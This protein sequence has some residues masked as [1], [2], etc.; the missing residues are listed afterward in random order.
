MNKKFLINNLTNSW[1][2]ENDPSLT[3]RCALI[4]SD[5]WIRL[6]KNTT[7]VAQCRLYFMHNEKRQCIIGAFIV[8]KKFRQKGYGSI[9]LKEVLKDVPH[10]MLWVKPDNCIA[11]HLYEKHGF[12]AMCEDHLGLIMIRKAE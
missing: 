10:A 8:Y 12:V 9:L 1:S 5:F 6:Y 3:F 4:D 7:V 2:S 11:K